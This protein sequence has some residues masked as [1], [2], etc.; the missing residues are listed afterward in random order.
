MLDRAAGPVNHRRALRKQ[1]RSGLAT[2]GGTLAWSAGTDAGGG[3]FAGHAGRALRRDRA[4]VPL[5]DRRP[6]LHHA[7]ARLLHG[8]SA[9]RH[10]QAGAVWY[11][12]VDRHHDRDARGA[13][14]RMASAQPAAAMAA[15]HATLG[16]QGRRR[17]AC[18]ALPDAVRAAPG[19]LLAVECRELSGRAVGL[20]AAAAAD[21]AGRA[22]ERDP[23]RGACA[24]RQSP[25]DP[26]DRPHRGG[27]APSFRA[28]GPRAAPD[29][30]RPGP[31][32]Q[33]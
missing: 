28:Q 16:A 25:G 27:A 7:R 8:G 33:R 21:R 1:T 31:A 4:G 11:P 6:D 23:A 24:R 2:P 13:A 18:A 3:A 26:G 12:Q 5:A 17:G 9:A 20:R 22:A 32:A 19:R 15:Q 29:A 10:P 30:A 14:P